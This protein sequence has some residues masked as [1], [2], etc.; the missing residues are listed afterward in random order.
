MLKPMTNNRLLLSGLDKGHI[1]E[2]ARDLN[3]YQTIEKDNEWFCVDGAVMRKKSFLVKHAQGVARWHVEMR[4]GEVVGV[5]V[6]HNVD[7]NAP[8]KTA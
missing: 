4:N 2:V 1:D 3:R 7:L 5:G 8:Y 6:I